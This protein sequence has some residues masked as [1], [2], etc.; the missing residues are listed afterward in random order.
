MLS[1]WRYNSAAPATSSS[2]K[3][4]LVTPASG[5]AFP[6]TIGTTPI[7]GGTSGRVLFEKSDH[8]VTEDAGL[9]FDATNDQLQLPTT[10]SGAGI[11]IGG[12]AQWY[13]SGANVLRTP[14]SVIVDANVTLGD[15]SADNVTYN[16]GTVTYASDIVITRAAGTVAAGVVNP[17]TQSITATGDAGGTSNI[18]GNVFSLEIQGANAVT[19]GTAFRGSLSHAGTTTL[20]NGFGFNQSVDITNTGN[21]ANVSVLSGSLSISSTGG[22]TGSTSILNAGAPTITGAGTAATVNGVNTANI[23][24]ANITTANAINI[25]DITAS[26][27]IR[28][29][30][31]AVSSGTGKR[32]LNIT[33]SADNFVVGNARFGSTTAPTHAIDV[34]GMFAA[35]NKVFPGTDAA[36]AQTACGIYAGTGVPNNA[37][38]A[39]GDY[40]FRSDGGAVTHLY[41]KA[42]GAW[43]GIV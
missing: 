31:C 41:F 27:N 12:D 10:G 29:I 4:L 25:A 20:T 26:T 13:R 24:H 16:A 3:P 11:L 40:Y 6:I 9:V 23:G 22:V 38:G 42:A 18:R 33:G 1:P 36:A 28:G 8:T 32:G 21:I 19:T 17:V 7:V 43:A 37:N 15:A 2:D 39:N 14:G 5:A 35:S 34:T 30:T